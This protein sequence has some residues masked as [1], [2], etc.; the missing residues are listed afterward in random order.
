V[1]TSEGLN[2]AQELNVMFVETSALTEMGITELFD[3]VISIL[4]GEEFEEE[5][6][7]GQTHTTQESTQPGSS[8]K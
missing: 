8:H 7:E 1:P 3:S 4:L 5:K 6:K 2:L